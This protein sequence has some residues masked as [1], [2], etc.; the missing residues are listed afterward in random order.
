M[1]LHASGQLVELYYS[2]EVKAADMDAKEGSSD[3][4]HYATMHQSFAVSQTPES[5]G[6][7]VQFLLAV[8]EAWDEDHEAEI[9]YTRYDKE[10]ESSSR[11][12]PLPGNGAF[13]ARPAFS[14]LFPNTGRISDADGIGLSLAEILRVA[15]LPSKM[16]YLRVLV[17]VIGQKATLFVSRKQRNHLPEI[18]VRSSK[19]ASCDRK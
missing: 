11:V 1:C 14:A 17:E 15:A 16:S 10:T 6:F 4:A 18:V 3:Y 7:P 12:S 5:F 8:K 13:T 2:I 19:V 9:E